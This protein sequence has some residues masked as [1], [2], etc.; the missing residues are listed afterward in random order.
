MPDGNTGHFSCFT[1]LQNVC[2]PVLLYVINN[3]VNLSCKMMLENVFMTNS[4]ISRKST[5]GSLQQ[6]KRLSFV[7]LVKQKNV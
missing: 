2:T 1:S 5:D 4:R 7:S 6:P 3:T